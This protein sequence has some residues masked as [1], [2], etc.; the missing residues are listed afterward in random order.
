MSNL[1]DSGTL[2]RMAYHG[3]L[4]LGVDADAVLRCAGL[5]PKKLYNTHLRTQFAAQPEFWAAAQALSNDPSIGLHL[6]ENM[7]IY[8]SQIFEHL[9][10]SSTTFGEGLRRMGN[11]Q[12]LI[13]D[14][15]HC[16]LAE[17]STPYIS[18]QFNAPEYAT[19]HLAEAMTIGLIRLFH[20]VTDGHFKPIKI[21]FNHHPN[22][23]LDE[24]ARI[25]KC[26]VEF[27][28][29]TLRLYFSP[30]LLTYRSMYAQPELVNLQ[31]IAAEKHLAK[32]QQFDLIRALRHS[33]G[34]SLETRQITLDS[35][36]KTLNMP[37][38]HLRY[39][40]HNAGTTFQHEL[41]HC[42]RA[43]AKKLLASSDE[44]ISDVVF[45]TG[46]SEASTF[47]RAFKRWEGMTPN[48]YRQF[49]RSKP[50]ADHNEGVAA[51]ALNVN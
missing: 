17:E 38:R 51:G 8:K 43:L 42:R 1:T 13:S 19:S 41:N 44:N 22:A 10:L 26:P 37:V 36:A 30:H 9:L 47:Y 40:L 27:N 4:T 7:P 6:G 50:S 34:G 18:N 20:S 29:E 16:D 31:L 24:Y 11:Y 46:F 2:V 5:E 45:L 39:A 33:L 23:E 14:A 48:A 15:L 3:L 35:I 25:F 12:R 28:A 21:T 32:L 49:H